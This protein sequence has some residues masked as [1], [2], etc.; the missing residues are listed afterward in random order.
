ME[1]ERKAKMKI[2]DR[3]ARWSEKK[4]LKRIAKK[5]DTFVTLYNRICPDMKR[6]ANIKTY[7]DKILQEQ[8]SV[9]RKHKGV[10]NGG[11]KVLR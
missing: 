9:V 8:D 1:Y 2:A 11:S 4:R 5:I 7:I 10:E 3:V 6:L